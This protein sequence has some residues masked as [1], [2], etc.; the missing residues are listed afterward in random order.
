[1][2]AG[3]GTDG[4]STGDDDDD[5]DRHGGGGGGGGDAEGRNA[6]AAG[7]RTHPHRAANAAA[8]GGGN[9]HDAEADAQPRRRGRAN[10]DSGP[11]QFAEA[12][13]GVAVSK[14]AQR[15]EEIMGWL[16][17]VADSN[18]A[19]K[20]L[21]ALHLCVRDPVAHARNSSDLAQALVCPP[22][23]FIRELMAVENWSRISEKVGVAVHAFIYT[24]LADPFFKR[25]FTQCF[26]AE[27]RSHTIATF[28]AVE[29]D[30]I[31][32]DEASTRDIFHNFS[33]QLFTVPSLT[34]ALVRD[35]QLLEVRG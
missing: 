29:R 6:A 30:E 28:A 8:A 25:V 31:D 14:A 22:S 17:T 4:D 1:M 10:S 35:H 5:E 11:S 19:Y 13:R 27:Y 16:N 26:I 12:M 18:A 7:E 24:L 20:R 32:S 23:Q 2:Q 21:V 34:S 15:F 9:S 3:T 33:V